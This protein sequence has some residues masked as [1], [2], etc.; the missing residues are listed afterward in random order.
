[1]KKPPAKPK[2]AKKAKAKAK[3]PPKKGGPRALDAL[4]G[5]SDEQL[6]QIRQM[7]EDGF[8]EDDDEPG[9]VELFE[10][11]LDACEDGA[12]D[13][14]DEDGSNAELV[15]ALSQL[16]ID[17]NGND[18]QAREDVRIVLELLDGDVKEGVLSP[19]N[20]V[21][22]GKL[23]ADA[24]WSLPK[25]FKDAVEESLRNFD[26][27]AEDAH[28]AMTLPEFGDLIK[29]LGDDAFSV[30]EALNAMMA[31]FPAMVLATSMAMFAKDGDPLARLVVCGFVLHPDQAV[32]LAALD[33]LAS[34]AASHPAQS[35]LIGRLVR[36]RPWL[37]AA[38]QARLDASVRA[39]RAN[40]LPPV[41][42][43]ASK[44]E[45]CQMS[46]CD[47]TG[48]QTQF[49]ACKAGAKWQIVSVMSKP[50]GV[51]DA[52]VI[53][54]LGK[55]EMNELL[56]QLRSAALT[57]E[58]GL[59]RIERMLRLSLADN[60]VAGTLPPYKLIEAMEALGIG[61]LQPDDSSPAQI[62]S[63][64]LAGLPAEAVGEA[65]LARAY[66][67]FERIDLRHQWF[68]SNEALDALLK[69][70]RG[71]AQRLHK[72]MDGYMP[73]RR[74]FW[75]R[76]CARSALAMQGDMAGP[77]SLGRAFALVGLQVASDAKLEDV[78]LLRMVA[79]SSISAYN[80]H[81]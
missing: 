51:V 31:S 43:D 36:M 11:H 74:A 70:V 46:V 34:N 12:F 76:Q 14:M 57:A 30:H 17:A 52:M 15:S 49:A 75:A 23:L 5:L 18:P 20:L 40:A 39:L 60:A 13:P 24:G 10:R 22:T 48:T 50:A 19:Q 32:G 3:A 69:G 7:I 38:R 6:A 28:D 41:A 33:A 35:L 68:D 4:A 42:A 65:A 59:E 58:G 67:T 27:T 64:L 9:A 55:R 71:H 79:E 63:G 56:G 47:G 1:M 72:V 78:Q 26:P 61:A 66:Q 21:L 25:S 44:I 29:D 2:K 45:T 77:D 54:G 62:M 73:G 37:P 81:R 80:A 8:G 53:A 16:R